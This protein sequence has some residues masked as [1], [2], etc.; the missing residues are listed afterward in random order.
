MGITFK[1]CHEVLMKYYGRPED[2]DAL[3]ITMCVLNGLF[4]L[5]AIMGN[6]LIIS[7]LKKASTIP[8]STRI[9]M[10]VFSAHRSHYGNIWS[11]TLHRRH[12]GNSPK[13]CV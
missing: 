1:L 2:L 9:L 10:L 5:T 8:L 7:A 13:V 6:V 12:F 3:Y 4:A 11:P